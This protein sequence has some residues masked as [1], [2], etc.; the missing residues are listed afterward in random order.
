MLDIN[1]TKVLSKGEIRSIA[2]SVFTTT[3]AEHL[4]ESYTHIPTS[5][6]IDDMELLGWNVYSAKEVK[7][8]KQVGFQKHLLVFRNENV[9]ING[10]DGDV[11]FP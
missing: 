9:V 6:V 5:R 11:V 2:P 1:S 10:D 7:A 4:S 8:R 3:Q